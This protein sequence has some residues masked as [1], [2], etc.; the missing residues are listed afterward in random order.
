MNLKD[1]SWSIVLERCKEID[2]TPIDKDSFTKI[3][4]GKIYPYY[5]VRCN[6]CGREYKT[7]FRKGHLLKCVCHESSQYS[8]ALKYADRCNFDLVET[9]DNFNNNLYVK[10]PVK[11]R[12]CGKITKQELNGNYI[13]CD[14]SKKRCYN[15]IREKCKT[16]NLECLNTDEEIINLYK[17]YGSDTKVRF[18]VRCLKCGKEFESSL[19][20]KVGCQNCIR[21]EQYNSAISLLTKWNYSPLFTEEQFVGY[22]TNCKSVYYPI[23]CNSCGTEFETT[24]GTNPIPNMCPSCKRRGVYRSRLEKEIKDY[25]ESK[26]IKVFSNYKHKNLTFGGRRGFEVDLYLPD[27]NLAIE[28]NGYY[29]HSS[30]FHEKDYHKLKTEICLKNGI[31][32]IHLWEDTSIG[33]CKSIIM[34]KLGLLNKVYARNLS[35]VDRGIDEFFE[36]NHV[37]GSCK[38]IKKFSLVDGT[39]IKCSLSLREIKIKGESYYEIARFATKRGITVVGGYSR[40]LKAAKEFI[41]STGVR[42]LYSYCNRDLSPDP[43]NNFYSNHGFKFDGDSGPIMK[44]FCLGNKTF[45]SSLVIPRQVLQKH[46]LKEIL[47]ENGI[48][49]DDSKTEEQLLKEINIV[50]VYNSGN[51]RYVLEF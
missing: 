8:R 34:S 15:T 23:K 22:F 20:T 46:K 11:C 45:K 2:V 29:W 18:K 43:F 21:L 49:Y 9:I 39:D 16:L 19:M 30:I 40:L 51:F 28:F 24:F 10:H 33:L 17:L 25:L 50:R 27:Y 31:K 36:L 13:K 12:L 37:D 47:E 3:Q 48:T 7:T 26:G 1:K 35:L 44:Y 38:S 4:D 32:L 41:K 5:F 42:K 14:C 6:K